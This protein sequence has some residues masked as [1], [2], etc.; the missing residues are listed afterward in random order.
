MGAVGQFIFREFVTV[1]TLVVFE[2]DKLTD[3][4]KPTLSSD[5]KYIASNP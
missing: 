4:E 2:L 5:K 3:Q 1:T